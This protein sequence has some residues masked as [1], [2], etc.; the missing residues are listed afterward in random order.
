MCWSIIFATIKET[1]DDEAEA[2]RKRD[3]SLNDRAK[4]FTQ[5]SILT[6]S[7]LAAAS[8][9]MKEYKEKA[10]RSV[11]RSLTKWFEQVLSDAV[12]TARLN[13][14]RGVDVV[15]KLQNLTSS[16]EQKDPSSI[17]ATNVWP[18]LKSRGWK[19]TMPTEGNQAGKSIYTFKDR[20][21]STQAGSK[22]Q[23]IL[24]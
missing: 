22:K 24:T 18:S 14:P 8:V 13:Q 21:V 11:V 7:G 6:S 12:E 1:A 2:A 15:S 4:T 10:F 16:E 9:D 3:Q 23:L 5:E 17:F 20:E 19:V